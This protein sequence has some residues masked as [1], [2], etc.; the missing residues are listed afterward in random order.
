M[1]QRVL[2][3]EDDEDTRAM[4]QTAL[5]ARG[6]RVFTAEHG[7]EG[8]HLARRYQPDLI[9]LDILMPVM[10]GWQALRYLRSYTE[11]RAIPICAISAYAPDEKELERAGSMD[12]D[13]F[14]IKPVEPAEVVSEV[15]RRIGRPWQSG[16]G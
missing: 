5:E 7:A 8:V 12:F 1:T 6:Y 13:C 10:D 15:E 9:L 2:I 3:V 4:Y 11:T 16:I 14:L